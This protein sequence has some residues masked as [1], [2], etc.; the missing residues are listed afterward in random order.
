MRI[1]LVR[2]FKVNHPYP[3]KRI[4]TKSDVI[5]WFADYD[6]TENLQY[7][8]VDLN[9]IDWERCYS[10][11]LIRTINTAKH[12][13]SGEIISVPQ[14]QELSI[15]NS[16]SNKIK[17]PFLIWGLIVRIK[18]FSSNKDVEAFEKGIIAFVDKL[19]ADNKTNTLIVS[20]WFVMRVLRKELIKRGFVGDKFKSNEYGTLYVYQSS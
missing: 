10:S 6:S 14:L 13:Y 9:G 15:L 11:T 12:I 2:H 5:N 17:L 3:E 8:T 1:G 18:S 20:H 4:L 19:I 7:K 16:L